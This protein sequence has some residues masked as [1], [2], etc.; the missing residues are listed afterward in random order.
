MRIVNLCHTGVHVRRA[1]P[2]ITL[3]LVLPFVSPHGGTTAEASPPQA[4]QPTYVGTDACA[5]CHPSQYDNFKRYAKKARSADH[6]KT[7]SGKLSPQE[8]AECFACHTTGYGRPGGFVSFETT[9]H[10]ADAGCEVCHGPGGAHSGTGDPTLISKPT[11]DACS[12]C[13]NSERVNSFN[14]K[15]LLQGGAH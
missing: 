3:L 11:M 5:D 15:P 12:E 1:L 2:A 8:L 14:Y 6:I 7:M 13:H 4:G 10:L 9:P